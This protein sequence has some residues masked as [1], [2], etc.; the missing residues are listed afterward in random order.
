MPTYC[1]LSTLQTYYRGCKLWEW[2]QAFEILQETYETLDEE[3]TDALFTAG[4]FGLS[5]FGL[6]EMLSRVAI[7]SRL[8]KQPSN[9]LRSLLRVMDLSGGKQR[10]AEA[11]R[12]CIMISTFNTLRE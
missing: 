8:D 1:D 9:A 10:L 2:S 7:R 5:L 3:E 11:S 6:F 12:G 4:N